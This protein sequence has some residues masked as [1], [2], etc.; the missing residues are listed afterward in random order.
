MKISLTG[1]SGS[2]K[3]FLVSHL[4]K[5]LNYTRMSFSDQLKK[6]AKLI[7]PWMEQDYPPLTKEQPLNLT[8]ASGEIITDT[9]RQIWLKLNSLRDV[10]DG[11]FLRMLE[12]EINLLTNPNIMTFISEPNIVISDIRPQ[13]EWDWCKKNEFTT[14]YIEP[15]KEIYT[16]NDFDKQVLTY[17]DK[18]DYVF[19]NNF[20]GLDEFKEFIKSIS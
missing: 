16:P 10:E 19:K 3:D 1:I 4:T 2:G 17:K 11:L 6:L 8:L 12:E 15:Q 5:E 18:A 20:N 13:L 14:I 9:P 7:Y